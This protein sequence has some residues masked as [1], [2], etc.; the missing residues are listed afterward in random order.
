M[1][2]KI[3]KEKELN[4]RTP[5][6]FKGFLKGTFHHYSASLTGKFALFW[7]IV[8][9]ILFKHI[10][11]SDADA[12]RILS[13]SKRGT[14]IYVIRNR[15]RLEYVLINYLF[16]KKGLPAPVFSHYIPVYSWQ[17][18]AQTLRRILARLLAII[19]RQGYLNP[20]ES[21]YV[22]KLIAKGEPTLLPARYFG[23]LPWRFG[24]SDPFADIIRIQQR[25]GSRYTLCLSNSLMAESLIGK[26][27]R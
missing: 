19:Q 11:I 1:V 25:L 3:K 2:K 18:L 4:R 15:S 22:E 23:G 12:K 7:R 14:I 21:G 20:Y 9:S 17:P 16:R 6:W 8:F 13:F 10:L 27:P 5:R 26:S 24:Q